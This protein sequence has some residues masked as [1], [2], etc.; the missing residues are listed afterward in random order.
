MSTLVS[1]P[2]AEQDYWRKDA[3][4]AW[5]IADAPDMTNAWVEENGE[6][7]QYAEM[8]CE[9][10]PVRKA[11]L[12]DAVRDPESEGLRGGYYFTSGGVSSADGARIRRELGVRVRLR[13]KK[14]SRA[15]PHVSVYERLPKVLDV[16][17]D[18]S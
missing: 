15:Q 10:C 3:A 6:N 1:K 14:P 17:A 2:L 8:V 12:L 16:S 13:Q 4:C 18:L 7:S 9:D 5:L 11:C